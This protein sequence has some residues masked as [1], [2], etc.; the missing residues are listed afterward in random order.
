VS[1]LE[2]FP[3]FGGKNSQTSDLTVAIGNK[4]AKADPQ[5]LITSG[6]NP[7]ETLISLLNYSRSGLLIR[8]YALVCALS[9]LNTADRIVTDLTELPL[10]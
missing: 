1:A 8:L 10:G 6:G 7:F 5:N 2:K 9:D 3:A 4:L